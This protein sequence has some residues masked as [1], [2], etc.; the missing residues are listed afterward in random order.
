MSGPATVES[1]WF[2]H[3]DAYNQEVTGPGFEFYGTINARRWGADLR[4]G[5][6]DE[7][8]EWCLWL[9]FPTEEAAHEAARK[10]LA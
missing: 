7:P 1:V 8:N 9:K 4:E 6:D 5:D 3:R 10:A 2:N